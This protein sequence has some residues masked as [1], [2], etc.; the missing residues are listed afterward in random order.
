MYMYIFP[1]QP[2][3]RTHTNARL[4]T[5][6]DAQREEDLEQETISRSHDIPLGSLKWWRGALLLHLLNVDS[7]GRCCAP[8]FLCFSFLSGLR[9]QNFS[10]SRLPSFVHLCVG[11]CVVFPVVCCLA[12]AGRMFFGACDKSFHH[13]NPPSQDATYVIC[14]DGR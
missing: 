11:E 9:W 14:T 6:R 2:N 5:G 3:S 8:G 10:S 7:S 4:R 12:G 13:A 1:H